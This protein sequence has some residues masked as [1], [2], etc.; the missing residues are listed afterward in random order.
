METSL[1]G[2]S[3]IITFKIINGDCFMIWPGCVF[4]CV[5]VWYGYGRVRVYGVYFILSYIVLGFYPDY[6]PSHRMLLCLTL[7]YQTSFS[8]GDDDHDCY[9]YDDDETFCFS[10]FRIYQ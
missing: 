7:F 5:F 2:G 10:L 3:L 6:G 8:V 9:Y 1:A 4:I